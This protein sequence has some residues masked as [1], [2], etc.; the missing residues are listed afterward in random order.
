VD[1]QERV[2]IRGYLRAQAAKLTPAE[3]ID[4]VLTAMTDLRRAAASVPKDRFEERP[5]PGEWSSNE[6]M[7]HVVD[8]SRHFGDQVVAILDGRPR[9]TVTREPSTTD[10][11]PADEW[12]AILE[13]DRAALF[14]RVRRADPQQAL[15]ETIEHRMF[16]PL[17]WR[18]V[19]LFMRLH[20]L[21]HV[22]QLQQIGAALA[23]HPA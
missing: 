4:K 3:V 1:D 19:L 17:T 13:H 7:A 21:D 10:R 20:D 9:V 2:R 5:A 22:G 8:A 6:V 23:A 16:G 14:D 15:T 11:F 18:E 12:S